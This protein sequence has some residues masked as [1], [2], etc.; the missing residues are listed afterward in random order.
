VR[1]CLPMTNTKATTSPMT[2]GPRNCALHFVE[3]K[4]TQTVQRAGP[5]EGP[6]GGSR[7]RDRGRGLRQ[8]RATRSDAIAARCASPINNTTV[9]EFGT[10]GSRTGRKLS[11]AL[12]GD[13]QE[14]GGHTAMCDRDARQGRRGDRRAHPRDHLEWDA[15]SRAR[16]IAFSP[17]RPST[18]GS[19]P[20][21]WTIRSPL[22]AASIIRR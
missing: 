2:I 1:L 21:R 18:K 8:P 12:A 10:S 19:P 5:G 16:A 6:V 13:D 4:R 22:R 11:S 15:G 7:E 3:V 20:F 17:A 9:N 14:A